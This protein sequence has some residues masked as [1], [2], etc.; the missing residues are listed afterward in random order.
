MRRAVL[1]LAAGAVLSARAA[2]PALAAVRRVLGRGR[3]GHVE[4][5]AER[6]RRDHGRRPSPPRR[7]SSR[8]SST[9]AT[10][11]LEAPLRTPRGE[12]AG[13]L[14]PRPAAPRARRRPDR[15]PLQE[16]GH[17]LRSSRTRCTSTASQYRPAPTAPTCPASPGRDG[18]VKPGQTWTYRLRAGSDSGGRVALPR[19]LAVDGA[20]DRRRPVRDAVDPRAARA[21]P[22][23]EFVVVLRARRTASRRSTA[24]HS[25][26]TRR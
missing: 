7:R 26:A 17:G 11:G 2:A 6:A 15:R 12:R 23:R 24:A 22:D 5:R 13:Q 4:R 3:A 18:D 10:R 25:S 14:D 21:P 16:H 1:V 8:R 20:V 9:A 19:P